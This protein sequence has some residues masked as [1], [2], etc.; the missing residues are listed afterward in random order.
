M[1]DLARGIDPRGVDPEREAKS[2]GAEQTYE[3]DLASADAIARSL[4]A[5][6]ERVAQ[7]LHKSGL[8]GRI[9]T[10]KLKYADFTLRTSPHLVA[11]AGERHHEH[12]PGVP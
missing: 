11:R 6:A 2:V 10:V 4:L 7:R 8:A 1:R 9:V 5:H 3:H 12:P